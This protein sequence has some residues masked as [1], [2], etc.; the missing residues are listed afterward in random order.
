MSI[1]VS[2]EPGNNLSCLVERR[3]EVQRSLRPSLRRLG[4]E[5]C[6]GE[7]E[8]GRMK[9]PSVQVKPLDRVLS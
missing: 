2:E 3:Q 5:S 4:F 7:S 1:L 9:G 6:P 8:T